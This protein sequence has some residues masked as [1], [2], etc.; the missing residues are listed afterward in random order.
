MS[1]VKSKTVTY[2]AVQGER[3]CEVTGVVKPELVPIWEAS[4]W[5]LVTR[6]TEAIVPV[7]GEIQT[8]EQ[9]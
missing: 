2:W 8:G 1:T 3:W 9:S 7:Y 6:V 5:R 4:G